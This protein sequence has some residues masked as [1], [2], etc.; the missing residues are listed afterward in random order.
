M[1]GTHP[2]YVHRWQYYEMFTVEH[3][4]VYCIALLYRIPVYVFCKRIHICMY[5]I[6]GSDLELMGRLQTYRPS[7][8]RSASGSVS[9]NPEPINYVVLLLC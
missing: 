2:I 4:V 9:A 3:M 1:K 5:Q 6:G 8:V 7:S